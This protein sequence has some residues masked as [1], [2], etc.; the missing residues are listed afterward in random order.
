MKTNPSI[1]TLVVIALVTCSIFVVSPVIAQTNPISDPSFVLKR[2]QLSEKPG[3]LQMEI[4]EQHSIG[5]ANVL[6]Y[7]GKGS[8][9]EMYK[10]AIMVV[11]LSSDQFKILNKIY[12]NELISISLDKSL[13]KLYGITTDGK[14]TVIDTYTNKMSN[15]INLSET[16]GQALSAI[17]SG[18][19][20]LYIN[21]R[22][23]TLIIIDT[24]EDKIVKRLHIEGQLSSLGISEKRHYVYVNGV[25]SIL[26]FDY[27][28]NNVSNILLQ[29]GLFNPQ[30]IVND[31]IDRAYATN[32]QGD[33]F[34]IDTSKN[35]VI[36]KQTIPSLV[37]V[38]NAVIDKKT[39]SF[40]FAPDNSCNI[41]KFDTA[42]DTNNIQ[43]GSFQCAD[44]PYGRTLGLDKNTD[45]LYYST[46]QGELLMLDSDKLHQSY[47]TKKQSQVNNVQ[48]I[49][50]P[51]VNDAQIKQSISSNL[52][53]RDGDWVKY[54]VIG[55]SDKSGQFVVQVAK[56]SG[57]QAT[58]WDESK[59]FIG[60]DSFLTTVDINHLNTFQYVI[61]INVK[62]GES[63]QVGQT[64]PLKVDGIKTIQV[65]GVNV[66]AFET[67][68]S[69]TH[70][71]PNGLLKLY[72]HNFYD[73]TTGMLL[74]FSADST[75]ND[76]HHLTIGYYA[77]DASVDIVYP[78]NTEVKGKFCF[79]FWCW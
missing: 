69:G 22:Q 27:N 19:H 26:V 47:Y 79:L 29:G 35:S 1:L 36:K 50:Q 44:Y 38:A 45:R 42:N 40:Y 52:G 56:I 73:T 5:Y 24:R 9:G 75:I 70:P 7:L 30:I 17:D 3:I 10:S 12:L 66:R 2:I 11:D 20:R 39:N 53:V 37:A 6:Y 60:A 46:Q 48:S 23:N 15:T 4:D 78:K 72:M 49:K 61:P 76:G 51:Q 59:R 21:D 67:S 32:Y 34:T 54:Q 64:E 65:S 74:S 63:I 62:V 41:S 25:N 77:I 71:V 58:F 13:N 43:N 18:I 68:L 55:T 28:G 33:V 31:N 8:S 14:L 57:T 16:F